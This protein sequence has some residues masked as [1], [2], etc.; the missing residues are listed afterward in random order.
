MNDDCHFLEGDENLLS[1]D[2]R[3]DA[4]GITS[5][6]ISADDPNLIIDN[7]KAILRY[8]FKCFE[9]YG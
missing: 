9:A 3:C 5:E 1:N 6:N 7:K 2:E 8:F 4:H